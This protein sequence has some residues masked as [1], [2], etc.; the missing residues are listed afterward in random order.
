MTSTKP[1]FNADL[2]TVEPP[3]SMVFVKVPGEADWTLLDQGRVIN[4]SSESDDREYRRLG[5]PNVTHAGATV[6]HDVTVQ[7]WVEERWDEVA[8][9]LGQPKA[10]TWD[11]NTRLYLD[12]TKVVDLM[13]VTYDDVETG[14]NPVA[15]EYI[16][17]FKPRT[18]TAS[19][20]AD[21][22][23]RVAEISGSAQDYY[24]IPEAE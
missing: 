13:V 20:E 16:N 15:V 5:D 22:E 8:H 6:S 21:G 10:G 2:Q 19:L 12:P 24:I 4:T 7:I 18:L 9:V 3:Q 14:A 11:G 23:A 17:S 1:A